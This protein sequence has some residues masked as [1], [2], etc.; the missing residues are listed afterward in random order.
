MKKI[1]IISLLVGMMGMMALSGCEK[2][3]ISTRK[4][5]KGEWVCTDYEY[6]KNGEL[7]L[8]FKGNNVTV[9]NT[10]F[11]PSVF[12]D[13]KYSGYDFKDDALTLHCEDGRDLSFTFS[14]DDNN[15]T[16]SLEFLGGVSQCPSSASGFYMFEKQIIK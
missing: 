15:T 12:D 6:S 10:T 2:S 5:I 11:I 9:I 3:E 8:I 14:I 1:V 7:K 13:K 4:H 16:M